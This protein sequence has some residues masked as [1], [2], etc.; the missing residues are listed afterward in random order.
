[1]G[2]CL[3]P[4]DTLSSPDSDPLLWSSVT[5]LAKTADHVEEELGAQVYASLLRSSY[6]LIHRDDQLR[7]V[8]IHIKFRVQ[9]TEGI[10]R[11]TTT[12]ERRKK[13]KQKLW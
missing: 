12:S 3:L 9:I 11:R 4:A 10:P 8:Y 13:K 5:Y 1:M 7:R 6:S 2:I